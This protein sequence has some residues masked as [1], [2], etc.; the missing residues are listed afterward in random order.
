MIYCANPKSVNTL[1]DRSIAQRPIRSWEKGK[2]H[3]GSHCCDWSQHP[4]QVPFS[5][6]FES[7]SLHWLFSSPNTR[8]YE[9]FPLATTS[10]ESFWYIKSDLCKKV[11]EG[12]GRGTNLCSAGTIENWYF[13]TK[14]K[15]CQKW[16]G[17]SSWFE[18]IAFLPSVCHTFSRLWWRSPRF[19]RSLLTFNRWCGR[20]VVLLNYF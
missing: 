8:T 20:L 14:G 19:D 9:N 15:K 5:S 13:L 12:P 17:C 6:A 4:Y 11:L 7:I 16:Y 10:S 3:K 18:V 1:T 2:S